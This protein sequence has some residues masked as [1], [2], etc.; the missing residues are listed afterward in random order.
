MARPLVDLTGRTYGKLTVLSRKM[1]GVPKYAKVWWLC[2]CECDN[3]CIA[4]SGQLQLGSKFSC[5]CLLASIRHGGTKIPEYQIWKAMKDRCTNERNPQYHDYGGR[6]IKVCDRWLESFPN[7]LEDMGRRPRGLTLER[8]DNDGNYEPRNCRWASWT[9]Q[10]RNT[11]QNHYLEYQGV[12]MTMAELVEKTGIGHMT[13]LARIRNGM[14]PEEAVARPIDTSTHH[15]P[16]VL[17]G[18]VEYASTAEAA[19]QLNL[20]RSQVISRIH[21]PKAKFAHWRFKDA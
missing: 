9:E 5:G 11:R 18:D 15:K 7:F 16:P 1:D 8:E 21:S 6:G 14:S 4:T 2:K 20:N 13:L 10:R 3:E 19:R 12:K 17:V